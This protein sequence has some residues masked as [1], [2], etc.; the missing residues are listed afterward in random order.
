MAIHTLDPKLILS[1]A[2]L[3]ETA[4]ALT[5]FMKQYSRI[6]SG[7]KIITADG[8]TPINSCR[9]TLF[10]TQHR[11]AQSAVQEAAEPPTPKCGR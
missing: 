7:I 10:S 2:N 9:S 3:E 4:T 8:L 5:A 1:D 11:A 6:A